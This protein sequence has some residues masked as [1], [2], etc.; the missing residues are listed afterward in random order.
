MKSFLFFGWILGGFLFGF[1]ELCAQVPSEQ[2]IFKHDNS[3]ECRVK[4]ADIKPLIEGYNPFFYDHRWNDT[5]K[6]ERAMLSPGRRVTIEQKACIRHHYYITLDLSKEIIPADAEPFFVV[7][8]FNLMNRI[9]FNQID[10]FSFKNE[11]EKTFIEQYEKAGNN[12]SFNFPLVDRTFICQILHEPKQSASIQLEI[13]RYLLR[14]NIKLPGV[15][16]YMDDGHFQPP[17]YT[18]VPSSTGR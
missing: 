1:T 2:L 4:Q 17:T 16:P 15:P 11:F 18:Q 3:G 14:E 9:Y 13:V 5:T 6:M 7:E 8:L 12:L 10:Y